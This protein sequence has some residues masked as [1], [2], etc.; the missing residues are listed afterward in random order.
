MKVK[1]SGC[2][3]VLDCRWL[4]FWGLYPGMSLWYVE[5][6]DCLATSCSV[7][8]ANSFVQVVSISVLQTNAVCDLFV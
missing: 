3:I 1:R 4:L 7:Y 6:L 8:S 2:G 5:L